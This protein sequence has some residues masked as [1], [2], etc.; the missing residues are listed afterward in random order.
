[1][2]FCFYL[3]NQKQRDKKLECK[4]LNKG[5][6]FA[7]LEREHGK[8][9]SLEFCF[10]FS[11]RMPLAEENRPSVSDQKLREGDGKIVIGF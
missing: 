7:G 8:R 1:M 4:Y 5:Q 11:Q 2:F 9:N 3:S 6:T 10:T